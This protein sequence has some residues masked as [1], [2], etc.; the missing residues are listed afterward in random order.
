MQGLRKQE[1]KG[2][3]IFFEFVQKCAKDRNCVFF[4]D[5]AQGD[6][7]SLND[8]DGDSLTGW[9]IPT[10]EASG[11]EK[12]FLSG[13]INDDIWENNYVLVNWHIKDGTLSITFE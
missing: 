7:F 11:F 6:E 1:D 2:F 12:S 9:L 8:M 3:E 10:N 13:N 5:T 4:C